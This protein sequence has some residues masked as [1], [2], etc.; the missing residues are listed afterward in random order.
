VSEVVPLYG[1]PDAF[2]VRFDAQQYER[3]QDTLDPLSFSP[4]PFGR[5]ATDISMG[6]DDDTGPEWTV[7]F[8]ADLSAQDQAILRGYLGT[9][10]AVI[11]VQFCD[12]P[13][14][15]GR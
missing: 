1:P 8:R 2:V 15:C 14:E 3:H 13:G 10:P 4:A 7:F 12:S 5:G 6:G 9:L 11:S